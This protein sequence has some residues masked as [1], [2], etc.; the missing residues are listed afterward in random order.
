MRSAQ[1]DKKL[2]A[3]LLKQ[4]KILQQLDTAVSTLENNIRKEE[5]AKL[6]IK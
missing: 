5:Q 2:E 3:T 1:G 6:G 4:E